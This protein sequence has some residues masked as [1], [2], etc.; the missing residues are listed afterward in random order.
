MGGGGGGRY[1]PRPSSELEELIRRSKEQADKDRLGSDVNKLLRE[2]LASHE[3]APEKVQDYLDRIGDVL[4]DEADIEQFLFGGS[5]AKH[6]YVDGL[7]DVDAL[8]VLNQDD[9]AGMSPEG[10]LQELHG[11]LQDRLTDS[12]LQSIEKGT[13]AVT[14]TY[15]DGTEI[16]LLPAIRSGTKVAIPSSG[17]R[18]WNETNPKVFQRMLT[19][20]NQRLD[21]TLI[22]T[23]KLVK[24]TVAGLPE[25]K[26]LTGYHAE[27]LSLEAVKGY[28]GTK[29]VKALIQHVFDHA[30]SRVRQ[31]I[32]D[33][34]GQSR[35]VDSYLGKPNSAKRRVVADALAG[36]AR[37]LGAATSVEQWKAILGI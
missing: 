6:T 8:V 36:I 17:A 3:R 34:T 19:R 37:R 28:R 29:T 24:S 1:F 10:V 5:V 7:S 23:I 9:V 31:P 32:N 15:R 27:A 13:M 16:Q 30:S 26:R 21:G 20:A 12:A 4:K 33:V 11:S 35:V 18:E 14:V 22:P 25:Q 2:I